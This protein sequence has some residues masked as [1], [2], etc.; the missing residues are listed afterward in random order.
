MLKVIENP[1]IRA[2]ALYVG[3]FVLGVVLGASA[4]L[5][6]KSTVFGSTHRFFATLTP[7]PADET[8][9]PMELPAFSSDLQLASITRAADLETYRPKRPRFAIMPYTVKEGDTAWSIAQE[10]DLKMESILW[11]N[12]G[13]SADA[14]ALGVGMVINILPVDG[15]LHTVAKDETWESL[16][17]RH[18][19]SRDAIIAFL[20]NG[21][22]E[23]A[24]PQLVVGQQ[25]II[26]GGTNPVT[27][28][29]PGPPLENG[30]GTASSGY[31]TGGL[32]N[33]G[34]GT[35]MLP[36]SPISIT[37]PYWAGHPA[38]DFDTVT[39]QPVYAA[40]SG[41]VIFSGWSESG[42]GNL[43]IIDHGTGYWT[44]YGHNDVNLVSAG[45]GVVQG[46]QI[47]RSGN[48]G[49][50]SGDHLDFR[51]R[52]AGGSFIDPTGLLPLP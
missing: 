10:F 29:D 21:L 51:I 8:A 3:I 14:G 38:I 39:G 11:G 27:W 30:K 12:E 17:Y 41:T 23:Q 9:V 13:M 15:V 46:Q 47:S 7:L 6:W 35:Y 25:L 20:G 26:P 22:S 43:I 31:Y 32:V 37:Q 5:V 48:T 28:V 1:K 19:V 33:M 50:S 49:N 52:V 36:V 2:A 24:D 45:Q 44:Y 34:T 16:E 4:S 42:Y 18:G 40:D